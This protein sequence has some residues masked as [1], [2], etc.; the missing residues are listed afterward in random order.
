MGTLGEVPE[1]AGAAWSGVQDGVIHLHWKRAHLADLLGRH[2][3]KSQ[4]GSRPRR[5]SP[6][7][8]AGTKSWGRARGRAQGGR[9]AGPLRYPGRASVWRAPFQGDEGEGCARGLHSAYRPT[10]PLSH[11]FSGRTPTLDQVGRLRVDDWELHEDVQAEVRRRWEAV[12]TGNVMELSDLDGF[13]RDFLRIFGFE[14]DG[15]DYDRDVTP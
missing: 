2:A 3:G 1:R 11:L 13:R 12:E 10:V 8:G 9:H 4:G 6:T 14:A 15:V 7:D 5:R